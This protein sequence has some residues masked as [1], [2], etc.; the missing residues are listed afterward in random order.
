MN[1]W[2][3]AKTRYGVSFLIVVFF[4]IPCALLVYPW[5][6]YMD[7]CE[8]AA[9][10][11]ELTY[12]FS[13]PQ[14]PYLNLPGNTSPRY[15]PSILLMA[16]VQKVFNLELFTLLGFSSVVSFIVL[17]VGVYLFTREYF[18]DT[19]QPLYSLLC[20]LFLWGKGWDGANAYMFSALVVNAYYPSIV[21]FIASFFA[22]YALLKYLK[23]H[24]LIYYGIFLFLSILI[25]LNHPVTGLLFFIMAF[26]IIVAEG[27]ACVKTFALFLAAPFTAAIVA[28]I[29]PYYPFF[30]GALFVVSGKAKQF[31]DY[32]LTHEFLYSD[33][34]QRIGLALLG[35]PALVYFLL[36]RQ[37]PFIV[38]GFLL[39]IICYG[40]SYVFK[41]SLGERFIFL[42]VLFCQLAFSRWIK[43]LTDKQKS[44]RKSRLATAG[45]TVCIIALIGGTVGQLYMVGSVYLPEFIKW[46]P[47]IGIKDYRTPMHKYIELKQY[48][49][50]G[51]TVLSDVCTS[52]VMPCITNTKVISLFKNSPLLIQNLE[53]LEDTRTFF[54]TPDKR[55]IIIEKYTVS[56]VLLNKKLF[57]P[58]RSYTDQVF[59]PNPDEKLRNELSSLGTVL[60]DNENFLLVRVKNKM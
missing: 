39:S 58:E 48:I 16:G 12:S 35:I 44:L 46:Q 60:L 38:F 26:L 59:I 47:R 17:G 56:H 55:K 6:D 7:G 15:V 54:S 45:L 9:A 42:C 10:V 57:P 5:F 30:N 31:W 14:N 49:G 24:A 19:H 51:N 36:K 32:K 34:F 41:L 22:L 11:R 40:M 33:L 37:Y 1:P 23:Q 18:E 52:W 8:H 25:F 21:S 2:Q 29:W 27:Y 13:N 50:R 4:F 43:L 3:N 28:G 20:L 53:R